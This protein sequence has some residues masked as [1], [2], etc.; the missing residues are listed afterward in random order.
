MIERRADRLADARHWA[1]WVAVLAFVSASA[2]I[3]AGARMTVRVSP[4]VSFAPGRVVV[5][6]TIES[7]EANRALQVT[8][9]SADYYTSST[10]HLD[11]ERAARTTVV[12]LRNLPRGEYRVTANLLGAGDD[13]LVRIERAVIVNEPQVDLRR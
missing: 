8:A 10:V 13:V 9:D 3:G 12:Q 5:R 1:G 7:N 6:A 4:A 11:G 2:G